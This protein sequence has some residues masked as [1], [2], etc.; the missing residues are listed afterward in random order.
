MVLN[1]LI[2][3]IKGASNAFKIKYDESKRNAGLMGIRKIMLFFHKWG[4]IKTCIL[5]A[6]FRF[7]FIFKPVELTCHE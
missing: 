3:Y 4:N 7:Y 6:F 1:A 5:F 2:S